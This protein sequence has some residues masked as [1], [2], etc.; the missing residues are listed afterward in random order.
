MNRVVL[1]FLIFFLQASYLGSKELVLIPDSSENS[2]ISL[3]KYFSIL[4]DTAKSLSFQEI[5]SPNWDSKF[6][7]ISEGLETLSFGYTRSAYWLKLTIKNENPRDHRQILEIASYP[8]SKIVF[9]TQEGTSVQKE[10]VTG[11]NF[12]F[13]SRAYANRFFVFPIEIPANTS[14]TFYFRLETSVSLI[15]QGRLWERD[16]FFR[17]ERNDY[18]FQAI[19]FGMVLAIL[20]YNFLLFVSIKDSL[21]LVYIGFVL[22]GSLTLSS[23]NGLAHEFLWPGATDWADSSTYV[24]FSLTLANLLL[25]LRKMLNIQNLYPK[26]D[27]FLKS[28]FVLLLALPIGFIVSI[29]D[30]SEPSAFLFGFTGALILGVSI[31]CALKRDRSAYFFVISFFFLCLGMIVTGLWALKILPANSLTTNGMQFGSAFEMLLL[32]FA[33]ADRFNQIKKAQVKTQTDLLSAQTKALE[34]EHKL[35]ETLKTSERL[36]EEKVKER[37]SELNK[38]LTIIKKDL[39]IAKKIQQNIV[40]VPAEISDKIEIKSLYLPMSEVGGDF[41]DITKLKQS[42][43]RIFLADATG[44]GVQ[45]AMVTMAIKGLYDNL[46]HLELETNHVLE[47]LNFEYYS[48][49]RSLNA[50]FTC[51]I[52]DI[53]LENGQIHF[54]SA[55]HPNALHFQNST[56]HCLE[57]TGKM[58]GLLKEIQFGK[59]QRNLMPRDRIYIYTDG[60]FEQFNSSKVEF[61]EETLVNTL[62]KTLNLSLDQSIQKTL[63]ELTNFLEGTERQDDITLIGIEFNG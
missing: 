41:F 61:G 20:I 28:L 19:Y 24:G 38:S 35:V 10:I 7:N 47:S 54:A 46:K 13:N 11:S 42:K 49:Y 60:M 59:L 34:A 15:V 32:A 33:L 16:D 58:V 8:I 29:Q 18:L 3:S 39:S 2:P 44:H 4:E 37:T 55:G 50:F 23:L 9:Y 36:L 52:L 26:I 6:T 17:H 27:L 62:E 56:V 45:A 25:L 40:S 48:K 30:F 21:Y 22:S 31:F 14:K 12:E 43:I 57:R 63:E 51:L 1:F 5:Q 53:D